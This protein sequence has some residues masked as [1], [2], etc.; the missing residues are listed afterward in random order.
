MAS[1]AFLGW[2]I[3]LLVINLVNPEE[4]GILGFVFFYVS[5]FIAL[6]GTFSV[7]GFYFR[8]LILKEEMLIKHIKV[9]FRQGI[10]FAIL[11]TGSLFLQ[12]KNLLTWWNIVLFI[13]A[14][15]LLELFFISY[16]SSIEK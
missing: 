1:A 11:I 9:S 6:W 12:S 10:L 8:K 14:L 13:I 16:K 5:L 7:M 4:A 15:T 3:W 2:L